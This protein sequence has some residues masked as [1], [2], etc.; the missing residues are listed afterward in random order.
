MSRRK[1]LLCVLE[2][3]TG[4]VHYCAPLGFDQVTLCGHTDWLG[5]TRGQD[6]GGPATCRTC[7]RIVAYCRG[8]E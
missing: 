2:P 8:E 5:E 6:H 3:D 7:I 1:P 4:E